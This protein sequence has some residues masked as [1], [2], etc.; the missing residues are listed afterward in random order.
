MI[1]IDAPIFDKI[2]LSI[3]FETWLAFFIFFLFFFKS[4][5]P[6]YAHFFTKHS[7]CVSSYNKYLERDILNLKTWSIYMVEIDGMFL[8]TSNVEAAYICGVCV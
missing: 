5:G 3:L 8:R 7:L 4:N 2:S 6:S 1:R